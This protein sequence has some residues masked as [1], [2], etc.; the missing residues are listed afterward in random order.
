MAILN[1]HDDSRSQ[2]WFGWLCTSSGRR[3]V[4]CCETDAH[5]FHCIHIRPKAISLYS[6]DWSTRDNQKHVIL[7]LLTVYHWPEYSYQRGVV[8]SSLHVVQAI[9]KKASRTCADR[10]AYFVAKRVSKR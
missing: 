9:S 4:Y 6:Q 1:R 5:I 10:S 2:A 7:I 3:I 8:P